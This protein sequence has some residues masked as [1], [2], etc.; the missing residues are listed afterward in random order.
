LLLKAFRI[1]FDKIDM[2]LLYFIY[3]A[4]ASV[5]SIPFGKLSDRAGRKKLLVP[6]YFLFSICYLGFA[7][8]AT[9]AMMIGAFI[10]YGVF[11]AMITGVERAYVAEIAPPALKGTMLGLQSTVT[12]IALFPASVITGFLWESFGDVVPFAFGAFLAFIAAMIL[13]LC[14]HKPAQP[15]SA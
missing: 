3:N 14:M 15:L 1:G 2:I 6:G 5:L 13:L 11:T 7:F 4:A 8:A 12:G 10:V 9:Q